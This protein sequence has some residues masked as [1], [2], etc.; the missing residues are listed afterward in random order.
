M[1]VEQLG[2]L[3]FVV[4]VLGGYPCFTFI[5]LAVLVKEYC[6]DELLGGDGLA[7]SE[8][9]SGRITEPWNG[10]AWRES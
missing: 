2:K 7:I 6:A 3:G 5:L 9:L 1:A 4:Q 10:L 8:G